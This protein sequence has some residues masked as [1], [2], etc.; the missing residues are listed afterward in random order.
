[1]DT[2]RNKGFRNKT[3]RRS[4]N[5]VQIIDL[6]NLE[7]SFSQNESVRTERSVTL[8]EIARRCAENSSNGINSH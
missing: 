3:D 5:G 6:D 2:P 7:V 4:A 8:K 1:M